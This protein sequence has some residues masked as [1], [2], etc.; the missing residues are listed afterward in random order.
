MFSFF[1]ICQNQN[2]PY[3][4]FLERIWFIFTYLLVYQLIN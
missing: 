2:N 1:K 3:S 4:N